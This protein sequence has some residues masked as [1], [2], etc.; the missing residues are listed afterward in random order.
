VLIASPTSN[1][2]SAE[3]ATPTGQVAEA[4]RRRLDLRGLTITTAIVYALQEELVELAVGDELEFLSV[5]FPAIA[6]DLEA[7]CRAAG[8]KHV[9]TLR[10]GESWRVRLRKGVPRRNDHR[11]AMVVSEDG[12]EELLSRLGFALAAALGG[13][14]VALY[15]QGPAVHVLAPGFRPRL[16]GLTRPFSRFA[17]AGLEKAG[18][19]APT[20]KLRQLEA[21][22]ADLYACGPSL[23]HFGVDP[24]RLAFERVTVCE[25]LTFVEVMQQADVQIYA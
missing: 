4:A 13:A 11:V 10:E 5:P 6:P 25:Y 2:Q 20:E 18:H 3:V 16:R 12:L 21:L 7:W 24:E 1:E 22:G 15:L 17:R 19:V 9:E 23:Q 14:R 8:H